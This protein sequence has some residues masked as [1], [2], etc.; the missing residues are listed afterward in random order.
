MTI[1]KFLM[2]VQTISAVFLSSSFH[3][4][5]H[6]SIVT[7]LIF[8]IITSAVSALLLKKYK[9]ENVLQQEN[10]VRTNKYY[11]NVMIGYIVFISIDVLILFSYLNGNLKLFSNLLSL[12]SLLSAVSLIE[13]FKLDNMMK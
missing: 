3:N 9:K 1:I 10:E 5:N 2:V 4:I 12:I 6:N 11:N 13:S 8:M 7:L